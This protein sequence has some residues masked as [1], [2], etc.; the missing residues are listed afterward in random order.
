M[1][2]SGHKTRSVFQR[3]DVTSE[4]DLLAAAV[5]LD[6]TVAKTVAMAADSSGAPR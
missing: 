1:K 2:L 3:Y 4:D 5:K 6:A